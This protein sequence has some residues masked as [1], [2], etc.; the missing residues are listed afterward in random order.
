MRTENHQFVN[1]LVASKKQFRALKEVTLEGALAEAE[2]QAMDR[3]DRGDHYSPSK[4]RGS[5]MDSMRRPAPVQRPSLAEVPEDNQFTIGD[6]EEHDDLDTGLDAEFDEKSGDIS[7]QRTSSAKGE[8]EGTSSAGMSAKARGKQ[9]AALQ[10]STS[11][12]TSTT[13][14]P[15]LTPTAASQVFQPSEHW[16]ES[17]YAEL[18]LD[19]ILNVIDESEVQRHGVSARSHNS[20][21]REE[22]HNADFPGKT[23]ED[24]PGNRREAR[25]SSQLSR[26]SIESGRSSQAAYGADGQGHL[27]SKGKHH[28]TACAARVG[29][30]FADLSETDDIKPAAGGPVNFQWTAVAVG[31]Y[32]ALIWSRI[33]LQEAE[34]FQGSGGLYSSTNIKLFRRQGASQEISLRSPKGAIDAVG[35]SLAQRISS[36]SIPDA[37]GGGASIAK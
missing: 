3:K 14:L 23:S 22:E 36:I 7:G 18:P 15:T 34:A 21:I 2:R 11:R 35:A 25:Q 10:I 5:S 19:R 13:S 17:W 30:N 26:Q 4:S 8:V 12:N 6:D 20:V 16:L 24:Q 31:W 9:R 32:N 1:V 33:Y 37:L 28:A 27:G 29:K